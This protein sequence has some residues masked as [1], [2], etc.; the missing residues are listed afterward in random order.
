MDPSLRLYFIGHISM[1]YVLTAI[2]VVAYTLLCCMM[3]KRWRAATSGR[4]NEEPYAYYGNT[5]RCEMGPTEAPDFGNLHEA[6]VASLSNA[7][8]RQNEYILY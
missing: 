2:A 3:V 1:L 4:Y 5:A 8:R 6:A 7:E